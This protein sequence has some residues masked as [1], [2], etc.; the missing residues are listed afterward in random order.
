[1]KFKSLI[2]ITIKKICKM[3]LYIFSSSRTKGLS[4]TE[5]WFCYFLIDKIFFVFPK[6]EKDGKYYLMIYSIVVIVFLLGKAINFFLRNQKKE[7][8]TRF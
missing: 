6:P 4:L 1:M 8:K 2:I 3:V 7:T 5:K